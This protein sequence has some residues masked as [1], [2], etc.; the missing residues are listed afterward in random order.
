MT[1]SIADQTVEELGGP[2]SVLVRQRNDHVELDRL[3]RELDG[4]KGRAQERVLRRIGRLV[5]SHAFAEE[6]VL[7][8][9]LRRTLPDG[10]ALTLRVE[11]EHQE[12]NEL[13]SEL[14]TLGHDDPRRAQRLSRMVDVLREDVRDEEDV[15]F[16]RLQEK[17]DSHELRRLGRQWELARRRRRPGRTP[18]CPAVRPATS[19]PACRCRC[20]TAPATSSTEAWTGP[21][22]GWCQPGGPS[23]AAWPRLRAWSSGYLPRGRGIGHPPTAD[24]G[25]EDG[26]IPDARAHRQTRRGGRDRSRLPVP[27][28]SRS[29]RIPARVVG[30]CGNE[31]ARG[32]TC[33]GTAS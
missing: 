22:S 7:W 4:S 13:A 3:L 28:G 20:W 1:R 24:P 17:L 6:T 2:G 19:S 15:L 14:E 33:L 30:R 11:Q 29:I 27:E 32:C 5:F 25:A 12:V 31:P 18:R 10:D 23:V 8:P 26:G 16:P 9:V 21:R